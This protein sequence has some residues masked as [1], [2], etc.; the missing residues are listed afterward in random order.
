[1]LT[2]AVNVAGVT[3]VGLGHGGMVII[4][5]WVMVAAVVFWSYTSTLIS[6]LAVRHIPQP[7]QT[8][9]DLLDDP[10][11]SIVT[12]PMTFFTESISVSLFLPKKTYEWLTLLLQ[13][14]QPFFEKNPIFFYIRQAGQ[15]HKKA[16]SNAIP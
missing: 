16:R 3:D 6:L 2:A 10:T 9:R 13:L 12:I 11:V 14:L 5:S 15:G 1:M 8:V 7:I 4:G